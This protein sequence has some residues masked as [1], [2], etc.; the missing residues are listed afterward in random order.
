MG[1]KL[2]KAGFDKETV[3]LVLEAW[4]PSTKK[5]YSNYL[6][7][8]ATFCLT[9]G[10]DL[11]QPTLAQACMFL[12][13]LVAKG[14]GYGAINAARSALATI[15]PKYDGTDFGKHKIVCWIVKAAYERNPPAPRYSTFWDVTKV[16]DLFK[17]W[18]RNSL[19]AL[20][21]LSFKLTMLLLLVT[22]QR[23]QTI[24]AL[25]V[26]NL[27][28]GRECVFKMTKL[29]KHNR[30]GDP[31][32]TIT[33]RPF[34]DCHRLCV[35]RCL[36]EY[37]RRTKSLR[38]GHTQLLVSFVQ[39]HKSI[40]RDTLARW[41]IEVLKLAGIDTSR[42]RS[43]STRGAAASAANKAGVPINLILRSAG[44]R[45]EHSFAKYYNKNID[46]DHSRVGEEL[47][48]SAL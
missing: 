4:R 25:S 7:K 20:K 42:Y 8:W 41:T 47:L 30:M 27:Q 26:E 1:K 2:L 16:F 43:H 45:N 3:L 21:L 24:I 13:T 46:Q 34:D 22:A 6:R 33:I 11:Y 17:A 15:L 31:L 38:K 39:P 36:K 9:R 35:V 28:L 32:D 48:R 40:S 10:V 5:V 14:L 19:L 29:L 44:W 37:I 12:R 23:G 18:G